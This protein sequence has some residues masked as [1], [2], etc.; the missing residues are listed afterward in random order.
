MKLVKILN[1]ILPIPEAFDTKQQVDWEGDPNT[2]FMGKFVGPNKKAYEIHIAPVDY[3][4]TS[5][6]FDSAAAELFSSESSMQNFLKDTFYDVIFYEVTDD[7]MTTKVTGT[8]GSKSIQVLSTVGNAIVDKI[9][10]E[11]IENFFFTAED[12]SQ[13][14]KN[15]YKRLVPM[16]ADRLNYNQVNDG[17]YFFVSKNEV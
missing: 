9:K 1:E 8:A 7:S 10:E 3:T 13:S 11:N 17:T 14:R 5:E 6:N 12:D 4:Q 2:G 16:I 15:L